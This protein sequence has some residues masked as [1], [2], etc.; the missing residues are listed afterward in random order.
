M[1]RLQV[2][3]EIT[4]NILK[5]PHDPKYRRL[6]ITSDRM[7]RHIMSKR[8]TVEFLQKVVSVRAVFHLLTNMLWTKMGFREKVGRTF[9]TTNCDF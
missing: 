1:L 6:K 9:L 3:N 7:N 5:N 8:G 4:E 2:L